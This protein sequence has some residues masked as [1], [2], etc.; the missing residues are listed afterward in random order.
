MYKEN[1]VYAVGG[2]VLNFVSLSEDFRSARDEIINNV[3]KLNW[4]GVAMVEF[5]KELSA[6]S[7]SSIKQI[8][9]FME[10][11]NAN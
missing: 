3:D 11:N 9:A 4:H 1:K 8:E 10:D 7:L 5:K 2:R 6:K